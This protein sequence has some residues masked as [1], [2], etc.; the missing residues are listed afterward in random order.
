MRPRR[1]TFAFECFVRRPRTFRGRLVVR[2]VAGCRIPFGL[3]ARGLRRSVLIRRR[4]VDARAACLGQA[5]RDRLLRRAR[6]VLAFADVLDLLAH[7]L[8]GLGAR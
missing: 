6:T 1:A 2:P 4:Q 5:D 8:A 3:L 7:E